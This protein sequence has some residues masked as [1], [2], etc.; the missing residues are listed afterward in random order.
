MVRTRFPAAGALLL[1]LVLPASLADDDAT[2]ELAR[3]VDELFSE[4]DEPDSPG[5]VLGV[6]HDGE[7]LRARGYGMA[8]LEHGVPL[9]LQSVMDLASEAKQFT[10][11]A[12]LLAAEEGKLTLDDDVRDH[13]PELPHY[14]RKITIRHLLHH[15]SGLRD[16]TVLSM[17]QGSNGRDL[18]TREHVL[19]LLTHQKELNF[20]PGTDYSYSNSGYFLA[21]EIVRRVTGKSL[22]EYADERIFQPLGMT[23]TLF[24]DESTEIVE[25]RAVG[26]IRV[27]NGF[28]RFV[29]NREDIGAAG[30][31]TTLA[32]L[33][34]WDRNFYENALGNGS[35]TSELVE[36]GV[37]NDGERLHYALG[38]V[39]GDFEG[40]TTVTHGGAGGGFR[41]MVLR[42]PELRFTVACLCNAMGINVPRRVWQ[43]AIPYLYGPLADKTRRLQVEAA[44][45]RWVE[46]SDEKLRSRAGAYRNDETRAIW[47][48]GAQGKELHVDSGSGTFTLRPLGETRFRKPGHG[49]DMEVEFDGTGSG[50]MRVEAE[51]GPPAQFTKVELV[52][53]SPPAL[54]EYAGTYY[55]EELQVPWTLVVRGKKLFFGGVDAPEDPLVPTIRDEMAL[56]PELV[57]SFERDDR[58]RI[59]AM[60]AHSERV[61]NLRFDKGH[62]ERPVG[63]VGLN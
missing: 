22:R 25:N 41:T 18:R 46:L 24:R 43:T 48:V 61:R 49:P 13:V 27:G 23:H 5:C 16:Y 29:T 17:M 2:K 63:D 40:L 19:D 11:A 31:L 6:F 45:P 21:G 37:L 54:S 59:V 39:V 51:A 26:H 32:D 20:A 50:R 53:P 44:P 60:H 9:S 30:L 7:V 15:T 52:S 33:A 34:R 28:G 10:A 4:F 8:N 14:G 12:V 58:N 55:S 47:H 57:I 62:R 36:R 1:F 56:P 42:F 3:S 35:L 38:L